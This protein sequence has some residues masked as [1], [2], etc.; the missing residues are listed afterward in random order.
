[1]LGIR[2]GYYTQDM[3]Q[4]HAIDSIVDYIEGMVSVGQSYTAPLLQGKPLSEDCD[5]F[6]RTFCEP[7]IKVIGDRLGQHGK[8]YIAGDKIT[9][10]DIKSFAAFSTLFTDMN[11]A[12]AFPNSV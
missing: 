11:P 4:A 12:S 5:D 8:K 1:M 9:I 10:A 3:M 2:L 7:Q 6:I